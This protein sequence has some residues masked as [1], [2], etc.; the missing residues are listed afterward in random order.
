MEIIPW[1]PLQHLLLPTPVTPSQQNRWCWIFERSFYTFQIKIDLILTQIQQWIWEK[2]LIKPKVQRFHHDNLLRTT[3]FHASFFH[4]LSMNTSP[5]IRTKK[6]FLTLHHLFSPHT[7]KIPL[8]GKPPWP[9]LS[10]FPLS[11]ESFEI[12]CSNQWPPHPSR[13]NGNWE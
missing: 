2:Q 9:S 6:S 1:N 7:H 13:A 3:P 8:L 4:N 12:P 5:H 10:L 11:N